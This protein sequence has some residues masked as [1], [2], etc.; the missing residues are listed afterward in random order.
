MIDLH[1]KCCTVTC[2]TVTCCTL[3][4][5]L[6]HQT[7]SP[8]DELQSA[9]FLPPQDVSFVSKMDGSEQRYVL[10]LPKTFNESRKV[11]LM[12]ALH[13]H[14]SDRWQFARD[15]RDECS[16]ARAL[17]AENGML[18]VCPDYRGKTSWMSPK[19]TEDLLQILDNLKKQYNL[20]RVLILGG[21]M[22]GSSALA[23]AAMHPDRV[24]GV[25]SMNGTANMLEYAGFSDAIERSYGASKQDKP[26][27]YRERSAELFADRLKFPIA[28]TTGGRDELVPP[29]STLRLLKQLEQRHSPCLL[30]HRPEGGHSTNPT[31]ART[32]IEFVLSNW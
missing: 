20:G 31:D 2:C 4:V 9:E 10:M 24:N 15:P 21:S 18:Y 26:E 7:Y 8:A 17:A 16:T 25:V 22:G 23:F 11:D 27:V 5:L 12:I 6:L 13:G 1:R 3:L 28:A 19:A 30:I 32:A 29:D 14:G